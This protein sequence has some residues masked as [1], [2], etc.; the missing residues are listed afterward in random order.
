MTDNGSRLRHPS[1]SQQTLPRFTSQLIVT[2]NPRLYAGGMFLCSQKRVRKIAAKATRALRGG[3]KKFPLG[4]YRAGPHKKY[5][6][7]TS[8]IRSP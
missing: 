6:V 4:S 8:K 1:I 5:Q 7:Y 3:Q 2:N